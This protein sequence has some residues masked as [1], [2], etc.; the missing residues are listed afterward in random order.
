MK[1]LPTISAI[2]GFGLAPLF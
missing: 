2:Y 1:G